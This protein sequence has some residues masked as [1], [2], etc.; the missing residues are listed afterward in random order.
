MTLK[1]AITGAMGRMGRALMQY[2]HDNDGVEIFG[3]TERREHPNIGQD[4]GRLL[5]GEPLDLSLEYDLRNTLLGVNAIID[6]TTPD[7]TLVNLGAAVENQIPIIIGTTGFDDK[8][9]EQLRELG[10]QTRTVFSPNMSV[11]VNLL[12]KLAAMA[13]DALGEEY[14]A[15]IVETHHRKKADSPSGTALRLAESVAGA[16]EREAVDIVDHGRVGVIGDRPYGRIG[17]HAVRGGDIVG[18]HTLSFFGPGEEF[19]I[20]HRATSRENFVKGAFRAAMFLQ[21][22]QNGIYSMLDVLKL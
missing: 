17:M 14:D 2:A 16:W 7:A 1:V 8:Q 3:A 9:L 12:W 20:G 18:E 10:E 15:E 6:F 21:N 13:A 5:F 11:G 22:A 4:I 19:F